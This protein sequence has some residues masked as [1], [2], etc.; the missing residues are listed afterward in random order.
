[1]KPIIFCCEDALTLLP[2][3]IARQIL[4]LDKWPEFQGYGLIPGVKSAV[5]DTQ[6]PDVIGTRIESTVLTAINAAN[7]AVLMAAQITSDHR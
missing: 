1:M 5:F 7:T 4:D 6:T 3:D 2:K